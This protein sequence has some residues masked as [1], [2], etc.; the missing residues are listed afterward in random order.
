MLGTALLLVAFQAGQ[1]AQPPPAPPTGLILGRVV[2]AASG[3]PVAG[4]HRRAPERHHDHAGRDRHAGPQPRAMTNANGQF[5]FRRLPKGSFGLTV[6]KPGYVEGAY[7]R[8]RPGG[9]QTPLEL[10]DGQRNG[11][12]VIPIWRFAAIAGTVTDEAGEP[13]VGV[14]VR[15]FERRY[16]AG[17]ATARR[18]GGTQLT[19]DR[20]RLPLRQPAARRLRRR[21]SSREKSRCRRRGRDPCARPPQRPQVPGAL[22]RADVPGRMTRP[23]DRRARPDRRAG[24]ASHTRGT[25]PA[26]G[27]RRQARRSTSTRRSSS[28][29]RRRRRRPRR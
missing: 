15:V 4:R 27:R 10:A 28:P 7:G 24:T 8:R 9:S 6:T 14:E 12:V 1:P 25:H 29:A 18:T 20:G 5:V 13:L 21:A 2:D 26:A 23:P 16:F 22:A 11:D 19:D 17:P 3:R